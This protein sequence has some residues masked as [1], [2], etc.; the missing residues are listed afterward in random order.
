MTKIISNNEKKLSTDTGIKAVLFDFGGVL[1]EEGFK[2]GLRA[3]ASENGLNSKDLIRTA[4]EAVY[5]LGFVTGKVREDAFWEDLRSS[6]GIRGTDQELTEAVL[7]RFMLRPWML[8]K[9]SELKEKGLV[10]G[11]FSDQTYWLDELD[12]RR[13]FFYYF[14]YVFNSYYIGRSK[15]D[16]DTFDRV[17]KRMNMRAENIL[18]VDDH[19][20]H[21]ERARSKGFQALFFKGKADLL[22]DIDKYFP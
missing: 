10:V 8:A 4:F 16:L 2:E 14:D 20:A 17:A 15:K 11:I 3:I 7:S 19:M 12:K 18:F 1:A 6:T 5:R 22:R 9:V 21:I 13:G